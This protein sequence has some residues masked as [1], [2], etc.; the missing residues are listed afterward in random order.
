MAD[1]RWLDMFM[2]DILKSGLARYI[3]GTVQMLMS[4]AVPSFILRLEYSNQKYLIFN[5]YLFIFI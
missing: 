2:V 3:T 4:M 1:G 5:E